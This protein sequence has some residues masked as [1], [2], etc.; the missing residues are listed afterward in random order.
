MVSQASVTD[1]LEE[2]SK[3]KVPT[4]D[5]V[6]VGVYNDLRRLAESYL[7]RERPGHTLQATALVHEAY[8]RLVGQHNV[9]WQNREQLIG[10]AAMMMRRILSNYARDRKRNKRGG[11]HYKLSLVEADRFLQ[12]VDMDIVALDDALEK[13]FKQY[14]LEGRI[15]ELRFFGGLTVEETA[16]ILQVSPS[17]IERGWKFAR[18]WLQC[19]MS[20][21]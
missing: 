10:V 9:D 5:D 21:W 11:G 20:G 3:G 4:G 19:E 15:I 12:Y 14:P 8:L 13:M 17:S 1:F 7:Q 18:A 16:E 2:I 6:L